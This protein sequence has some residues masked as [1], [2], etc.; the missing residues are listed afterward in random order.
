MAIVAD[1]DEDILTGHHNIR[2]K[3]AVSAT[4]ANSCKCASSLMS[5]KRQD[6]ELQ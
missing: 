2:G 3:A 6:Y 4:Q 5:R 1:L